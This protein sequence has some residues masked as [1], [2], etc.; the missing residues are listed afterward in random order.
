MKTHHT[1]KAC[2]EALVMVM[3]SSALKVRTGRIKVTWET[4]VQMVYDAVFISKRADYCFSRQSLT[5]W[6][7]E[8]CSECCSCL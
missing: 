6:A 7:R 3:E 2:V 8:N 5:P 1:Q 4:F